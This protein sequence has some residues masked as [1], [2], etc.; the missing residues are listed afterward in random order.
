MSAMV[1]VKVVDGV[2]FVFIFIFCFLC[3]VSWWIFWVVVGQLKSIFLSTCL[4]SSLPGCCVFGLSLSG[5]QSLSRDV[6]A[7]IVGLHT[8]VFLVHV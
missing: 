6:E 2:V 3:V 4:S 8:L 7:A 1:I 5:D